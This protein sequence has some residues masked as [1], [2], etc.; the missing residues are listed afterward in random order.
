MRKLIVT[1]IVSLDGYYEGPDGNVMALPMDHRF[2]EYNVERLQAAD[3][4]LLGHTTFSGFAGYWPGVAD[5]ES[6]S[7][8]NRE[9]SRRNNAIE[10]VA[11]G[12]SLTDDELG[13]WSDTTR[14]V[15]RGDA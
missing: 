9:I 4:L 14:V 13:A 5:D 1:N 2:D 8:D 3:T 15:K 11:I 10:K 12:D 6:A 7:A